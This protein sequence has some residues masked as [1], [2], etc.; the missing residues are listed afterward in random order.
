MEAH[1]RTEVAD[2]VDEHVDA[3]VLVEH[4][5]GQA[6][7]VGL[8]AHVD[9]VHARGATRGL[10]GRAGALG[11]L[12]V[13]LGDLDVRTVLGEEAGDRPADAVAAPGDDGDATVE[14]PVP[15]ADRGHVRRL[16]GGHGCSL[17]VVEGDSPADPPVSSRRARRACR[18]PRER[19]GGGVAPSA[20]AA[21]R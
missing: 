19:R 3:A 12:G 14:E 8:L 21:G 2:V 9:H 16:L 20:R 6:L 17:Q 7:D 10:D 18:A 1:E 4:A 13:D 11:A 15:I 5:G